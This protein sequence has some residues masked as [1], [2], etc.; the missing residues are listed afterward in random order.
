VQSEFVTTG[1]ALEAERLSLTGELN[2]VAVEWVMQY[3]I[4]D[5]YK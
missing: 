4:A 2:V 1:E 3:T 5:A